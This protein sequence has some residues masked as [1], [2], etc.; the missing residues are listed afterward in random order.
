MRM[1]SDKAV[2]FIFLL[3]RYAEIK[4]VSSKVVLEL[5]QEKNI[6]EYINNMYEQYNAERIENAIE[7]ID[8][9][10]SK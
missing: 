8:K 10:L 4:K 9:K 6:I 7:D 1:I 5:W 3:E 2:F